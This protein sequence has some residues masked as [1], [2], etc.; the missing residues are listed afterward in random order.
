MAREQ[1]E[2]EPILDLVDAVLDSN[3]GRG[4]AAPL[5]QSLSSKLPLGIAVGAKAQDPKT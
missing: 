3:T 4:F 2:I 5:R 1:H